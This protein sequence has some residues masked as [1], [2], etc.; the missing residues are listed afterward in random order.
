[1]K[2]GIFFLALLLVA[3]GV[4]GFQ[5]GAYY[6]FKRL[7]LRNTSTANLSGNHTG[8]VPN[9]HNSTSS[10]KYIEV[11][12][13]FNYGNSTSIW[14]NKTKVPQVW[15]FYNLTVYLAN[16]RV[17]ASFST[18][19]HEHQILGINGLEQN[20][21]DYWSLWKFCPTYNAWA[22]SPVGADEIALSN[23]GIYGWY[24]QN[25]NTQNAPVAGAATITI[26]D[27]SSC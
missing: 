26:L 17:D 4:I 21:T 6:E 15:N 1:M 14:F 25:Y 11:N 10:M 22:W 12:T 24:Y 16:R 13:I 3:L 19:Y 18:T 27:I 2:K 5:T 8:P 9:N 7:F 20:Q 23:N